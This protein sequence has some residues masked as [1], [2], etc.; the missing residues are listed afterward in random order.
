[1][2]PE[3]IKEFHKLYQDVVLELHQ[4]TSEHIAAMVAENRVEYAIATE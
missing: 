4:G 2:L 3:I 1:V